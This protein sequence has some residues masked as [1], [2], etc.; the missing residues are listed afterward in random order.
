MRCPSSFKWVNVMELLATDRR[1]RLRLRDG[2]AR[3]GL[4]LRAL[5]STTIFVLNVL[6]MFPS[7]PLDWLSPSPV[8]ETVHYPTQRGL[9]EGEIWR[10]PTAGPHPAV[11]LCLGVIPV[12]VVHPQVARLQESLA[13][14]GFVTLLYWSPAMRDFR[15]DPDDV[16]DLA[17]AYEWLI[18]QPVV[19]PTR[20]GMIGTCVG[21]AFVLMAAAQRP[22]RK[23]VAFVSLFAP[24]ASMWTLARDIAS[25]SWLREGIR[26]RWEV[27]PLSR[28]VYVHSMTAVLDAEEATKLREAFA[29]PTG[30]LDS[31]ELSELGQV[32]APLLVEMSSEQA[33]SEFSRLPP[34]LQARFDAMSP[35]SY[36]EDLEAP[37]ISLMHDRDD[38]VIPPSE[39]EALR[40]ALA[41]RPG[42][43]YTEFIMFKHLDPTKVQLHLLPLLRELGR[44]V[45][46]LYPTF[47]RVTR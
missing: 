35:M 3:I 16:D 22:I 15:L 46:A 14:A 47:R 12:D 10:P 6:P 32:I 8:R 13:R 5:R 38:P 44:F 7:R 25:A 24:Y 42:L 39:S 4:S 19:D 9:V 2:I 20:S 29:D 41:D 27:D 33:E 21:G 34:E 17:M 43:R 30:Q 11:L 31:S 1:I 45:L 18:A 26:E 40:D 28:K 23:D 37:L 36:L